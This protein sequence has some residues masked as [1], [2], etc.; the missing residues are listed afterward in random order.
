MI[1]DGCCRELG[2][3]EMILAAPIQSQDPTAS[4]SCANAQNQSS[5]SIWISAGILQCS[6]RFRVVSSV[7]VDSSCPATNAIASGNSNQIRSRR[8]PAFPN[9]QVSS[10]N[11]VANPPPRT[12]I[13]IR[14]MFSSSWWLL[15]F[16]PPKPKS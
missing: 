15:L 2:R 16:I 12:A 14:R 13:R 1:A 5:L 9:T 7:D 3:G 8:T 11:P 4:V 6:F 10:D